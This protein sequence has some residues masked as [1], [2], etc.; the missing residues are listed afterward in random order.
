MDQVNPISLGSALSTTLNNYYDLLKNQI[1]GLQADEFLQLKLVADPVDISDDKYRYWSMYNLL[2]RSDVAIEPRPVSG[3]ILTSAD[4][5]NAVYGAFLQRL[6]GYVVR[7]ELST[8]DQ[9]KVADI[10]VRIQRCKDLAREYVSKDA[11]AWRDYCEITGRKLGDTDAYVQ[12][13]IYSGYSR[14]IEE[15]NEVLRGLLFDRKTI[16]DRQYA[17]PEDRKII[18]AEFEY[19]S[20]QMRLRYPAYPDYSYP[21]GSQFSLTYLATLPL[22]SSALFDDRRAVSWNI[23]RRSVMSTLRRLKVLRCAWRPSVEA[24]VTVRRP[25]HNDRTLNIHHGGA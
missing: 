11:A 24:Y 20:P 16:L 18:D 21:N 6:R 4:R 22:G 17:D 5:L 9:A 1:G 23:S 10:D 8:E 3:T 14:E 25:C 19:E 7:K 13:S 15:Q 2:N 12:W